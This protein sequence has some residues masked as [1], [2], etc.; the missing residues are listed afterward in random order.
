MRLGCGL[1]L[2]LSMATASTAQVPMRKDVNELSPVEVAAL[3][4]A[5][6]Q[7]KAWDQAP[8]GSANYKRS[9]KYWANMHYHFGADCG[10]PPS[11]RPGM[12]GQVAMVA[13][14]AD[15][16]ATWCK[17]KHGDYSFLT[18]H[19]MYL[20]YFE[21]VLQS[22][23]GDASLRLPYWDYQRNPELPLAFRELTFTAAGGAKTDNPLYA[24]NRRSA[25]N[26]GGGLDPD[27]ADVEEAFLREAYWDEGSGFNETL[28][29][30]PHGAVHCAIGAAGCRSGLMGH[31][32]TAAQDPIFYL[33]HAN[34]DRLYECWLR[35]DPA[36]RLP[37]DAAKVKERYSFPDA[38][39]EIRTRAVDDMLQTSQL[40]YGYTRM[41]S[42]PT[43]AAGGAKMLRLTTPVRYVVS[44]A[45][46]IAGESAAAPLTIPTEARPD[47]KAQT[48]LSG[49]GSEAVLAVEGLKF[50]R[51]PASL[52]KVYLSSGASKSAFIGLVDFFAGGP[53]HH[54]HGAHGDADAGRTVRFRI[55]QALQDLNLTEADLASTRLIFQPATGVAGETPAAGQALNLGDEKLRYEAI[56]LLIDKP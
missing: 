42:C 38:G 18:W 46:A 33:H 32:A 53:G 30:Q 39:G 24:A 2:S 15:E 36:N 4:R 10:G 7:M 3:R 9:W 12:A 51:E 52:Y 41:G 40:G 47:V 28:E 21:R 5:V 27:V 20:Y 43:G 19:R 23:A 48:M 1:A 54:G 29:V 45:G 34:I 22:A 25:L 16:K 11:N 31:P 35:V 56:S 13:T 49:P 50:D 55:T 26:A 8:P 14:S 6:A 44:G 37:S 17:C